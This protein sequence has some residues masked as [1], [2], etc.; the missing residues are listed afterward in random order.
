MSTLMKLSATNPIA[1]RVMDA[2]NAGQPRD[3]RGRWGLQRSANKIENERN[4]TMRSRDVEVNKTYMNA[5][6]GKVK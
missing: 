2:F 4:A 5:L 3:E 6:K 1:R